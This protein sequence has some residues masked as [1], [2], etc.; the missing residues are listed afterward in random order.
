M[1]YHLNDIIIISSSRDGK[2][3][4]MW[5]EIKVVRKYLC[6]LTRCVRARSLNI[7]CLSRSRK[8]VRSQINVVKIV[9][10]FTS[11]LRHSRFSYIRFYKHIYR[12]VDCYSVYKKLHILIIVCHLHR[13]QRINRI[14]K[15]TIAFYPI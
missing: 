3:G 10:I 4:M 2:P 11:C 12:A 5:S 15:T 13:I 14:V 8:H 1:T 7:T 9:N 6:V